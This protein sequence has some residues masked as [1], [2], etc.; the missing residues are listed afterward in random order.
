MAPVP[1]GHIA[2]SGQKVDI[3]RQRRGNFVGA[4]K[5]HCGNLQLQPW[6]CSW[7]FHANAARLSSTVASAWPWPW[8]LHLTVCSIYSAEQPALPSIPPS[9]VILTRAP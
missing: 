7:S 5:R 4:S 8:N 2:R 9:I 3:Q 1:A 6:F